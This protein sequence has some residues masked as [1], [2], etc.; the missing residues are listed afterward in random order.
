[1][2]DYVVEARDR[3]IS[4]TGDVI[5]QA[6]TQEPGKE[7]WAE[8]TIYRTRSGKYVV[9]G[10]GRTTV[11]GEVDRHWAHSSGTPEGVIEALYM[12]DA[13]EVRYLPHVNRRALEAAAANDIP[14][15]DASIGYTEHVA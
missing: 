12:Y 15:N 4:F 14:I 8:V 5:G 13:D 3:K 6:T 9:A 2:Q 7:R 10:C 1:M 11:F